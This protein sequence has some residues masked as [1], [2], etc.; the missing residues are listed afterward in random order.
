LLDDK[1][2]IVS[3]NNS[4]LCKVYE[5][6]PWVVYGNTSLGGVQILKDSGEKERLIPATPSANSSGMCSSYPA[7]NVKVP[8]AFLY[9]SK[10]NVK[11]SY[12]V[13]GDN[14]NIR[15]VSDDGEWCQIKYINN[16]NKSIES[17]LQCQDLAIFK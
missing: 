16:K 10:K 9:D 2:S 14:L 5:K 8:K 12:L 13:K 7:I 15:S 3:M 4:G 11:K 1:Y 6:N 17:T